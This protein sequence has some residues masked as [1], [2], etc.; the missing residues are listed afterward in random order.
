MRRFSPR[1]IWL[2][3]TSRFT[4]HSNA[5]RNY[6]WTESKMAFQA[7]LPTLKSTVNVATVLLIPRHSFRDCQIVKVT[8]RRV[9]LLPA[10]FKNWTKESLQRL[11]RHVLLEPCMHVR[12]YRVER[13]VCPWL[14]HLEWISRS[15]KKIFSFF[16]I[17]IPLIVKVK[18]FQGTIGRNLIVFLRNVSPFNTVRANSDFMILDA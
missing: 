13:K 14:S 12:M 1:S 2:I 7:A 16:C 6:P 11:L 17:Y 18:L 3:S 10:R 5:F 9:T 8:T 15:K 4:D